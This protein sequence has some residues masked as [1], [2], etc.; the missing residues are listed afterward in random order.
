MGL[1]IQQGVGLGF[2]FP[3][4]PPPH[5]LIPTFR[6]IVQQTQKG[7]VRG[8]SLGAGHSRRVAWVHPIH[9]FHPDW[10]TNDDDKG[11]CQG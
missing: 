1:P 11:T 10:T 4:T 6:A 2:S 5:Y 8:S 3:G 7:C 9:I